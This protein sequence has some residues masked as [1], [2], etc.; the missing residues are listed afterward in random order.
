MRGSTSHR[1]GNGR[2]KK[3]K[4]RKT[5]KK[6]KEDKR[7]RGQCKGVMGKEGKVREQ[8]NCEASVNESQG[9]KWKGQGR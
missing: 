6:K 8:G 1:E 4:E 9:G 5:A 7:E 3:G 2:A